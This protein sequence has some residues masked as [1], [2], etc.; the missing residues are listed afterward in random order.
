MSMHSDRR[1]ITT[2]DAPPPAGTY[3]QAVCA[4]GLVHVAGQTPRLPDG[5][6]LNNAPFESQARQTLANVEAIARA[7]GSALAEAAFCTVYLTD[8]EQRGVFDSIWGEF[9]GAVPPSRA[10]VQSNLPGFSVEVTAVLPCR[11]A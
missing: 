8:I 4:G 11:C 1:I 5:T 2:A 7:A 9:V 3:S 6:R 10:I